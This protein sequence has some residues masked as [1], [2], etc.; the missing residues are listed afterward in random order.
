MN[1]KKKTRN[2]KA[3]NVIHPDLNFRLAFKTHNYFIRVMIDEI[4]Y[5]QRKREMETVIDPA[6]IEHNSNLA[7]GD[8]FE[9]YN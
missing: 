5:N 8:C 3:K 7:S 6:I 4:F 9:L 2:R 1:S